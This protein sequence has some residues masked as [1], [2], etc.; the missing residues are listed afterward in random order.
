[1]SVKAHFEIESYKEIKNY[2]HNYL[3]LTKEEVRSIVDEVVKDTIQK[4]VS[5][6]LNDENRLT[7]L[8]EKE[9]IR[10]LKYQD[11]VRNS[12][13]VNTM[14]GIYNKIDTVIHE[15][16]IKRLQIT[17]KEPEEGLEINGE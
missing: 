14:D 7:S 6:Y 17:L 10:Q 2:I 13:I 3:G 8:V 16:V 5:K 15:E 12:F 9:I 1:M 11:K 4:E